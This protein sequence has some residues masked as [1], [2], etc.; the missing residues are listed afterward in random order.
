MESTNSMVKCFD[1]VIVGGGIIGVASAREM[2][3]RYPE[4]S[5]ALVEKESKLAQ[6]QT[7]HNSGV[8]HSGIYYRPGTLKAKLCVEGQ[9]LI[10]EYLDKK[11]IPYKKCG[12]LIVATNSLEVKRLE[13]LYKRAQQN[14]AR[15][16][17]VLN[18]IE[19][20]KQIEPYCGGIKAIW[21]P[22][23]GIVNWS[24]VTE[25]L[26]MDFKTL[27]GEIYVNYEVTNTI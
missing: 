6:H 26:A 25:Q 11:L 14:Q 27:G 22:E 21:C 8:I 12:K 18:N 20:I 5:M 9:R 10:Y 3:L 17:K 16:I 15:N 19:E 1:L 4:L 7:G 24:R 23:T 2:K 13:D